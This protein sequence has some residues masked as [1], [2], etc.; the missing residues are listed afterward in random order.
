MEEKVL[1]TG[2]T[3]GLGKELARRFA[4]EGFSLLL[5]ARNLLLLEDFSNSLKE[6]G[7]KVKTISGDLSNPETIKN[8]IGFAK[9][10]DA[11]LLINN[12]GHPCPGLKLEEIKKEEI[13]EM[14]NVNLYATIT[15]IR[16]FYMNLLGKGGCII[17]INSIMGREPKELRSIYTAT[18]WGLRGFTDSFRIEAEKNNFRIIGVYP[19]RIKTRPEYTF[20]LEVSDVIGK[21]YEYYSSGQNGD[22]I[23][24]GR[25]L[26][27][28]PKTI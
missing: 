21:I 16:G 2:A 23:I 3:S 13:K 6:E 26:E 19:S 11:T 22:I 4:K 27:L 8:L 10:N 9:E 15:L 28:R 7:A 14:I 18:R 1:I 20:G 5:H 17:N 24:D 12:A 25:P